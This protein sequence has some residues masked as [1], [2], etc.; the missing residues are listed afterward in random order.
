MCHLIWY[1]KYRCNDRI[2]IMAMTS[3]IIFF[4]IVKAFIKELVKYF[5]F[6]NSISVGL[7]L[8]FNCTSLAD[9]H[10]HMT[11]QHPVNCCC[12]D[13][14][15]CPTVCDPMACSMPG[16]LV[17]HHLPEFVQTHAHW[18]GDAIQPSHPLLSPSPPAFN[19]S[20]DQG[21]F[22]WVGSLH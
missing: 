2:K 9:D 6:L 12:W 4:I 17:L 10:S 22:W 1:N 7:I 18:V 3:L 20:Q 5:P 13:A 8:R 21:L 15:S 19:L 16:F 14:K 11:E